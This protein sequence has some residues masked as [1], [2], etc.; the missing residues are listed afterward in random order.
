M[1]RLTQVATDRIDHKKV[2]RSNYWIAAVCGS[3]IGI[4]LG[5]SI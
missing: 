1:N 3:I 4:M 5:L 2:I